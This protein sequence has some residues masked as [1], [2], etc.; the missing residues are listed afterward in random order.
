MDL[1]DNALRYLEST[2]VGRWDLVKSV[3]LD[4]NPW[5]CDCD[6][7]WMIETLLPTLERVDPKFGA[8]LT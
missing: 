6:N 7:Q 5:V 2:L 3:R 1:H 8:G 4:G